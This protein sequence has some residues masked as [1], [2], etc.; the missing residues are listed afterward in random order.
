MSRFENPRNPNVEIDVVHPTDRVRWG[1]IIAGVFAA[2]TAAAVLST[3]GAAIGMSA[4]DAS[5]DPRRFAIGF[6]IWGIIT[7]LVAYALGGWLAG[8]SAAFR[9]RNNGLLNGALVAAVG[10]PLTLFLLGS[11]GAVIGA[12]ASERDTGATQ[13]RGGAAGGFDGAAQASASITPGDTAGSGTG[14]QASADSEEAARTGS[15]AAWGTLVALLLAIGAA[16]VG[17]Y[18]GGRER[19]EDAARAVPT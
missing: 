8:R 10:I 14:A 7:M 4:Y 11:A 13:A 19:D 18:L 5:D 2:M 12:Q 9:G 1:P 15:R 16:T 17:G 6:G 3:L